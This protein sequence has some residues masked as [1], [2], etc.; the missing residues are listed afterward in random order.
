MGR[1]RG[2]TSRYVSQDSGSWEVRVLFLLLRW[3]LFAMFTGMVD[4]TS[5]LCSVLGF[6][7]KMVNNGF[8][9]A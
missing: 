2:A 3:V 8:L 1:P 4:Y 5:I 9:T 7:N 6:N